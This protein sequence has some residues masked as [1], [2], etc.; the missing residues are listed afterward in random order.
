MVSRIEMMRLLIIGAGGHG[1]TVAETVLLG[2][3][4]ELTAFLD[5]APDRVQRIGETPV[6]GP[7]SD[8]VSCQGRVDAVLVAIGRNE[9]RESLHARVAALGLPLAT[10]VHPKAIVS[11]SARI[12]PG[13]TV[14]TGAI[15]GTQA[16]LDE[17]VIINCGAIVDHDCLVEAFG[18]LGVGAC[19]SGGAVLGRGAWMQAGSA[20]GYGVRV[21]KGRVLQPAEGVAA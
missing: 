10:V 19:M 4:Y 5:D 6:W 15:I 12:G 3:D 20:L 9:L 21:P 7:T 18:H 8:L 17:G 11:P 13:C 14:M 2:R 1:R 16:Q